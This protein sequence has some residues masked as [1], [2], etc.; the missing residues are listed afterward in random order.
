MR[1]SLGTIHDKQFGKRIFELACQ[2]INARLERA[3]KTVVVHQRRR[4]VRAE[5]RLCGKKVS[6]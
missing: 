2:F 4:V 3:V 1:R 6:H 5:L